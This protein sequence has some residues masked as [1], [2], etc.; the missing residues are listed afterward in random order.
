MRGG[1]ERLLTGLGAQCSRLDPAPGQR[2]RLAEVPARKAASQ[3]GATTVTERARGAR[4]ARP[5]DA[6]GVWTTTCTPRRTQSLGR[7][8][9]TSLELPRAGR[10]GDQVRASSQRRT[11]PAATK[12]FLSLFSSLCRDGGSRCTDAGVARRRADR[13][14]AELCRDGGSRCTN[15]ALGGVRMLASPPAT[16]FQPER[17][18]SFSGI[19]SCAV[20]L[21]RYSLRARALRKRCAA[22]SVDA[23]LD[24]DD[25]DIRC[26]VP[27][28]SWKELSSE[29]LHGTGRC[30]W[31]STL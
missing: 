10:K 13:L 17:R 18:S 22:A 23:V 31:A 12:I 2:Q 11:G 5:V 6:D 3:A 28:A 16:V 24:I 21:A 9:P 8:L 29:N 14:A 19:R 27:G 30:L 26:A 15:A 25:I 7:W 1:H 20:V 4:P